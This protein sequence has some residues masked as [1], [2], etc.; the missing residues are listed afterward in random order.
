MWLAC[1]LGTL[2]F[3]VPLTVGAENDLGTREDVRTR[4]DVAPRSDNEAWQ[5]GQAQL[6]QRLQPGQPANMYRRK[7][8]DMGYLVTSVNDDEDYLEYEIVKGD[9]TYEVQINVDDD[10]GKATAL[11]IAMN[12]WRTDATEQALEQNRA[13]AG[14]AMTPA[15]ARR[16]NQYSDRDRSRADRFVNELEALPTGRD[17]QY[18]KDELK[19]K[20]YQ[21][22]KV[23]TDDDN[24]LELEAVKSGQSFEL[25]VSFDEDT[26]RSTAVDADTL[27]MESEATTQARERQERAPATSSNVERRSQ[28][29]SR[30]A[31]QY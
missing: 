7:I 23:N 14:T 21:I 13:T 27:W 9:Q 1:L 16:W 31:D 12:M 8:E 6:E 28:T 20:G 19:R 10:T 11:D 15:E 30:T 5:Q 2:P 24:Q 29:R 17:K 4:S 25:D 26:G 22:T 18:Y 3:A